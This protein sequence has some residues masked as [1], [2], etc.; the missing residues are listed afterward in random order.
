MVDGG[1]IF[2][3]HS[4]ADKRFVEEVI[5]KIPKSHLFYDVWTVDPGTEISRELEDNLAKC[6][7][8]VLF[9][10]ENT[11]NSGWVNYEIQLAKY[12]KIRRRFLKILVVPIPPCSHRDAPEWM[13][14]YP[15]VSD[16]YTKSDIGRTIK[17]MLEESHREQGIAIIPLFVGR[18]SLCNQIVVS[19]RSKAIETGIPINF[20]V[21]AGIQNMGR[22]SV[23][24]KVIPEIFPGARSD[25]PVF[26]LPRQADA[27]DIYI[28]LRQDLTGEKSKDEFARLI[29]IFPTDERQQANLI[30]ENLRHFADINQIVVVRCALGIRDQEPT[31]KNWLRHLLD[32]L[33]SEPNVR[34]IW[35]SE[36]L[37]ASESILQYENVMQFAIGE[38][39]DQDM[40]Y[41]LMQLLDIQES[42]PARIARIVPFLNG[43]PAS[44]HYVARLIR[45]SQRS[46]E[47]IIV[48]PEAVKGFQEKIVRDVVR[49]SSIGD[50]EFEI[51][52]ILKMLPAADFD[53]INGCFPEVEAREI[54][55]AL[56]T[57]TDNCIASYDVNTG[58]KLAEIIRATT[59]ED[60]DEVPAERINS[61]AE[62]LILRINAERMSLYAVES[63]VFL[64]VRNSG[65]LPDE[66]KR[67]LTGSVLLDVVE[68]LYQLGMSYEGDWKSHF[69][70]AADLSK[71]ADQVSISFDARET[72]L[73]NG[74]ESLIRIGEDPSE[75]I[76]ILEKRKYKC[77]NYLLGSYYFHAKKN[78]PAAR[79]FLE[80]S[81]KDRSFTLRTTRLLSKIYVELGDPRTG[82][83]VLDSLG[84]RVNR[85][86]G[87][88]A[89]KIRCLKAIGRHSEALN[90]V[91]VLGSSNDEFGEFDTLEAARNMNRGRFEDALSCIQRARQKHKVNRLN[92][93]LL[94]TAIKIERGDLSSIEET[95]RLANAVGLSDA[96]RSLRARAEISKRN[97][98]EA[99]AQVRGMSNQ[100]YYDKMLL[101]R[102]LDIKRRDPLISGD[103]E[104]SNVVQREF[105]HLMVE[106]K[107]EPDWY[108]YDP[109]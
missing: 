63:L 40:A 100:N 33:R 21:F 22:L 34:I 75:I 1:F 58:Y 106:L 82:L 23:A 89:Q 86:S 18:E 83:R 87:L 93:K 28:E 102:A 47:S 17:Y 65:R 96:V 57:V 80:Q 52:K 31:L 107:G 97:W 8:F 101:L 15:A 53:L 103:I 91:K 78:L 7:V 29:E 71:M 45:D 9:L 79:D 35:I 85:D 42:S 81:L 37:L 38:V 26:D 70:F 46:P 104:A 94:E 67:F 16:E 62:N 19:I 54:A 4:S 74:A 32:L 108:E 25:T 41:M 20:L 2:L 92:L 14:V 77:V 99:E 24:R 105:D 90:L 61:L 10:S 44:A 88:M 6:D 55:E 109:I 5:S 72:A 11:I 3:S 76:N 50:L 43:H 84:G 48:R 73:F 64:R 49:R 66:F 30:F 39:S 69:R 36:R 56:A 12:T 13:R 68:R 59:F 95:C 98:R 51:I 27:I 60:G